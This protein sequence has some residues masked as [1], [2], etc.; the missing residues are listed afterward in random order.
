MTTPLTPGTT[1]TSV[2]LAI[3]A[4]LQTVL[5]NSATFG[6]GYPDDTTTAERYL[7]ELEERV[8]T[9]SLV[10]IFA[11][12]V[13]KVVSNPARYPHV[14]LQS[15]AVL[16]LTKLMCVSKGAGG[17]LHS[18]LSSLAPPSS[19]HSSALLSF[20]CPPLCWRGSLNCGCSVVR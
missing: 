17:R 5:R 12:L 7:I 3:A 11:P 15:S 6:A 9:T 1:G 18:P 10:A 14:A 19:L 2:D 16:A 20:R 8:R 13:V 4:A